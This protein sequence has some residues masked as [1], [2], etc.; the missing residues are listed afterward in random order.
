MRRGPPPREAE[1]LG[2]LAR[3]RSS[4]YIA[5]ALFLSTET[6]KVHVKHIYDKTGVHSRE[7]LLD[8]VQND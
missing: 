2:Y 8:L 3:G 4:T 7:D 6:V 1:V 5:K